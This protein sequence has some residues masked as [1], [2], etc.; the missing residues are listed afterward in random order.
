MHILMCCR[1][2]KRKQR[3]K[4]LYTC[5]RCVTAEL[6]RFIQNDNRSVCRNNVNRTTAAEAVLLAVNNARRF[7]L[8]ALF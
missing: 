8:R 1:V 5:L 4:K 3:F 2:V 7:V 6:L